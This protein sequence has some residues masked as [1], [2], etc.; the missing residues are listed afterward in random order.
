MHSRGASLLLG[1]I[2]HV[3]SFGMMFFFSAALVVGVGQVIARYLFN[4]STMACSGPTRPSSS[5]PSG[6]R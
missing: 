5:S 6:Q 2:T 3:E 4:F 1:A